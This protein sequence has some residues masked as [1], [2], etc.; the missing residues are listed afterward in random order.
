MVRFE[1]MAISDRRRRN[2]PTAD[3]HAKGT[4]LGYK[5]AVLLTNPKNPQLRGTVGTHTYAICMH[6]CVI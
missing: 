2:M 6:A 1:H 4:K 3:D 5:E